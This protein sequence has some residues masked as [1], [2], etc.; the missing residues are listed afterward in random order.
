MCYAP[1]VHN[2]KTGTHTVCLITFK[3]EEIGPKILNIEIYCNKK[4]SKYF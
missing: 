3:T 4:A 1:L 2:I